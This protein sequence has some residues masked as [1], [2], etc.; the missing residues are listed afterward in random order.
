M[1]NLVHVLHTAKS[2]DFPESDVNGLMM[3]LIRVIVGHCYSQ[4]IFVAS[5]AFRALNLFVPGSIRC[6]REAVAS[7][8]LESI[9]SMSSQDN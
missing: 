3:D 6:V 9:E 4:D 5:G 2:S 7:G 8:M 1:P